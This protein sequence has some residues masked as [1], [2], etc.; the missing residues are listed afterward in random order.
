MEILSLREMIWLAHSSA[1]AFPRL[2]REPGANPWIVHAEHSAV[3]PDMVQW[4]H[5]SAWSEELIGAIPGL[6]RG[7]GPLGPVSIRSVHAEHCSV[8]I[9]VPHGGGPESLRTLA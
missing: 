9:T 4:R 1:W 6:I 5:R 2:G 7:A 8:R 3:A